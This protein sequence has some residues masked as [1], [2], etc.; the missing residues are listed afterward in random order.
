MIKKVTLKKVWI[1]VMLLFL[2]QLKLEAQIT[3]VEAE[4]N[5]TK[6]V[7]ADNDIVK[8]TTTSHSGGASIMLTDAT[9]KIRIS[10]TG[11]AEN[12]KVRVRVRSGAYASSTGYD[13]PQSYWLP[14]SKYIFQINGVSTTLTGDVS[15]IGAKDGSYGESYWGT[16]VISTATLVAGT[17]TID[18]ESSGS[19][20]GV[21]YVEIEKITGTADTQAP[22]QVTNLSVTGASNK[23]VG[24]TWTAPGDD[25]NV[26]TAVKYEIRYSTS[27]ITAANFSSA[28][29]AANIPDPL[30]AGTMQKM[31]VAIPSGNTTY[32]IAM[33]TKDEVPNTSVLSNVVTLKTP[34]DQPLSGNTFYKAINFNGPALTIDG[35]NW[36]ASAGNSNFSFVGDVFTNTG[37]TLAPATDANRTSMIRSSMWQGNGRDSVT[38]T[39]SNVPN[40]IY[41]VFLYA[42]EDSYSFN[43][44]IFLQ[45]S[46]KSPYTSGLKGTWSKINL[47]KVS[48]TAGTIKVKAQGGIAN[49]SGL[50][51]WKEVA[52][53]TNAG[54]DKKIVFPTN[55]VLIEGL[56][57]LSGGSIT[58]YQWTKISGPAATLSGAGTSSLTAS[59]L[60]VG[61]YVFRLTTTASNGT[62]SSDDVNVVVQPT[63][64]A[65]T[66]ATSVYTSQFNGN[67]AAIKWGSKFG[68]SAVQVKAY[69]FAYDTLNRLRNAYYAEKTG[70]T[71]TQATGF[72]NE[73]GITYDK[74]GNIKTMKRFES[75]NV[76]K[77]VMDNLTYFYSG[78]QLQRVEDAALSYDNYDNGFDDKITTTTNPD[79]IYDGNGNLIEDKHKSIKIFYNHLNLPDS[80]WFGNNNYILYDYTSSG[81]KFSKRVFTSGALTKTTWYDG[82][83]VFEKDGT[84]EHLQFI[85]NEEGRVIPSTKPGEAGKYEYEYFLKDHLGNTRLVVNSAT[86]NRY[87]FLATM[88][89][90]ND[91]VKTQ[92]EAEFTNVADTRVTDPANSRSGNESSKLNATLGKV[93]GPGIALNVS[94]GDTIKMEVWAKYVNNASANYSSVIE[95][96]AAAVAGAYTGGMNEVK[97]QTVSNAFAGVPRLALTNTTAPRA[98]LN[99]IF[100]DKS[101]R[102]DASKSG[103]IQVTSAAATAFQ[104]LSLQKVIDKEGYLYVYVA[105]ES[106]A[107]VNVFFDDMKVTQVEAPVKSHT[108]Y[109]PFGLKIGGLSGESV[110]TNPNKFLYNGKELQDDVLG[111][112]SL[113]MYDYGARFYDPTIGRWMVL[114]P[115]AHNYFSTSPYIYAIDNPVRLIDIGGAGPGDPI[116]ENYS[117]TGNV[118]IIIAD[119]PNNKWDT[120]NL[121]N[122]DW[123]YVIT[124]SPAEAAEWLDKTYGKDGKGINNLV[125]RTHGDDGGEEGGG[126]AALVHYQ[127]GGTYYV[128][129][130]NFDN[131]DPIAKPFIKMGSFLNKNATVLFT[132]CNISMRGDKLSNSIFKAFNGKEKNLTLYT[133]RAST[134]SHDNLRSGRKFRMDNPLVNKNKRYDNWVKTTKNGIDQVTCG[135]SMQL[136]SNGTITQTHDVNYNTQTAPNKPR[137]FDHPGSAGPATP[138]PIKKLLQ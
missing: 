71:F 105:N 29:L 67:I 107:D 54:P 37:V 10:F 108:D 92:E 85:S 78:N 45:G 117:G 131:K 81:A 125:V 86:P 134:N 15:S 4:N 41:E 115:L 30:V 69:S 43:Y 74:N 136:N 27:A 52:S 46:F 110:G 73:E 91:T 34:S 11:T 61:T 60:T 84:G 130:H 116:A 118:I 82:E 50:E 103:F 89:S 21:D 128:M 14:T 38:C 2:I 51:I 56:A 55:S 9:D 127:N 48:V 109:Y 95:N 12:Y 40:G 13:N 39:V 3:R 138:T 126:T 8:V 114:D 80:I 44:D 33:V 17:N 68:P 113:G 137:M 133:N 122:S 18:I 102:Y 75:F 49:I 132:A 62:T 101:Y 119:H 23:F 24:L 77:R 31:N 96:I 20:A 32:Y 22:G 104:L 57:S 58:T 53:V 100:F 47:G 5:Y 65:G 135:E 63:P 70:T 83:I 98:Y 35:N 120:K 121:D 72:Y 42:W 106:S 99:Y 87:Q 66:P 76:Q 123:D 36:E 19:Y 59:G 25:G 124:N 88:E 64:T 97:K 129:A 112:I 26:G 1:V 16:M 111:G 90:E 79:Y 7:D 93:I 6:L 28:I 94:P